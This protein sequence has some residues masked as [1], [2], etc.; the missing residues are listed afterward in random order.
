MYDY[1]K[2]SKITVNHPS[3]IELTFSVGDIKTIYLFGGTFSNNSF[4]L[5]PIRLYTTKNIHKNEI[6]LNSI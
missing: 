2:M 1:L 6:V 5:L 3:L 4:M